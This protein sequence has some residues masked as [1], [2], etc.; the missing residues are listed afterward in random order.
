MSDLFPG[1]VKNE[2]T[3]ILPRRLREWLWTFIPG[4]SID[5]LLLQDPEPRVVEDQRVAVFFPPG[6]EGIKRARWLAGGAGCGAP[7]ARAEFESKTSSRFC[8]LRCG[9]SAMLPDG[10]RPAGAGSRKTSRARGTASLWPRLAKVSAAHA[11]G[12]P[13]SA[14]VR[15]SAAVP[16][17]MSSKQR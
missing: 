2:L 3:P 9:T 12:S 13:S 4:A 6:Q 10:S 1:W 17:S 15:L 8:K 16:A 14:I 5:L 11:P 7:P